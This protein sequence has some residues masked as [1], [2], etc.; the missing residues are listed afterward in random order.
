M[1]LAGLVVLLLGLGLAGCAPPPAPPGAPPAPGAGLPSP[2]VAARNFVAVVERVEPVAEALCRQEAPQ[3]DCDYRIVVDT[4]TD[5][6]PNALHTIG[7]GGEPIIGFNIA[8]I[9][10]V[11]NQDELAFILGH[12]A[13]HHIAG[14][15]PRQRASALQG[16]VLA[17]ALATLQGADAATIRRA[18]DFGAAVGARRYSKDFELEA[19]AL[20]TVIAYRAGYDPAR[21]AEYFA[22]IPDPGNRFLGTHPPNAARVGTVQETLRRLRNP[23]V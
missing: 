2:E 4:R 17:G 9:A 7:P 10:N 1:R 5:Q 14:H 21:G 12:E 15:I 20:G 23:P 13:A 8:L 18:Q 3:L 6:P 11:R 22:R 19:D 16:A